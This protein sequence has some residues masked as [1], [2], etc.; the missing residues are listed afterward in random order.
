MSKLSMRSKIRVYWT[1]NPGDMGYGGPTSDWNGKSA[2]YE[3]CSVRKAVNFDYELSQR[4][5]QGTNRKILYI[6]DK[7]QV[8]LEELQEVLYNAEYL[9][10]CKKY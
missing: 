6:H 5:G 4:I 9:A 7:Q 2:T 10:D 8:F 3:L 1:T